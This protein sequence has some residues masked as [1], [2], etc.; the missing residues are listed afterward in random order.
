MLLSDL[1]DSVSLESY[2]SPAK[3]MCVRGIRDQDVPQGDVPFFL[4]VATYSPGSP[5]TDKA[6]GVLSDAMLRHFP[7]PT[8]AWPSTPPVLNPPLPSPSW[9]TGACPVCVCMSS[10]FGVSLAVWLPVVCMCARERSSVHG[11]GRALALHPC[12]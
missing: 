2:E 7:A 5:A 8:R 9:S 12:R 1:V 11:A 4:C 6:I 3:V 10:V